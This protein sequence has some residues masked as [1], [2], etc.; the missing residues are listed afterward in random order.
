MHCFWLNIKIFYL[1]QDFWNYL[2]GYILFSYKGLSG[3]NV[4]M[5]MD[6]CDFFGGVDW[7]LQSCLKPGQGM[8]KWQLEIAIRQLNNW[9]T[10]PNSVAVNHIEHSLHVWIGSGLVAELASICTSSKFMLQG[11]IGI[12][13]LTAN[14]SN[15]QKIPIVSD[16]WKHQQA[17]ACPIDR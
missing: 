5:E 9:Q 10:G 17:P 14:N 1:I 11:T 16:L 12:V 6:Y 2:C 8:L 7:L 13:L 4:A 3:K 15:L